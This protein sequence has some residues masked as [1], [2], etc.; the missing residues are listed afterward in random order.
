MARVS[1]R[2]MTPS[3]RKLSVQSTVYWRSIICFGALD[4]KQIFRRSDEALH[5]ETSVSVYGPSDLRML[6]LSASLC[7]YTTNI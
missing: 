4:L 2:K 5:G 1:P 3:L 7:V 6:Y